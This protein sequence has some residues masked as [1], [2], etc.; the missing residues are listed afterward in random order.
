M[1]ET[2]YSWLISANQS[3]LPALGTLTIVFVRPGK[4]VAVPTRQEE[5]LV[6]KYWVSVDA[7]ERKRNGHQ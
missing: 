1:A 2:A 4:P 7:A 6:E 3:A 5:E